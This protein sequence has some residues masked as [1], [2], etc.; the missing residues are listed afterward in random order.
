M[1]AITML[2]PAS[3]AQTADNDVAEMPEIVVFGGARDERG[4]LE[5]PNPVTIV[6][7]EEIIRRQPSTYE[8]L[9]GDE[10]GVTIEGGPRSISQEPNIRGFRDDQVLIR[11]DGARQ[12]FNIPHRG[13]FFTDPTIVKQ[14][15]I[16]R[17]GA[18]T[19]FGSGA[20]GGVI[21]LDTKDAAD[22]L[23][24][25]E[26]WGG[27]V[28]FGFNSQG[29][30]FLGAGTVV[31]QYE[32]FD[33]LAFF[34]GRPMFSD[35]ED[36]SNNDII[37]SEIDS[38]N[39]LIKLGWEPGD[40]HRVEGSYQ[41][42]RDNGDTPP[43]ANVQG[44]PTTVVDR[45]LRYQT[46]RVAWDWA[47]ADQPLI[48]LSTL[49]YFN[50][51]NVE[52]DRFFDGRFDTT[53]LTTVGIEATNISSFQIADVP[54]DV[55][56]GIEF[57]LDDRVAER[58]GAPRLQAPDAVR[59]FYAAFVQADFEVLPGLTVTPG[60]RY[61]FFQLRPDGAFPD[62]SEGQP[63]PR[64]AVNWQPTENTQ[65][66]A[67]A[68]RSFRAPALTELYNDGVHF[69]T[70]GFPLGPPGAPV[71]TGI[72]QFVPSPDL[73][74]ERATQF[75][76][77]G[78]YRMGGLISPGDDLLISG[79]VYYSIVDDFVDTVVTFIDD[80]T[81]SFNPITG[82]VEVGGTTINRNVDAVLFGFEAEIEYDSDDWFASVGVTIPRGR[83][84]G[85]PG[86]LASIPADRL[87]VT[88]GWRPLRDVELGVR[89][90]FADGVQA[91]DTSGEP[92]SGYSVFDFF[93][94]WQP[95]DG[96]LE[97]AI[98]SAGIDNLTDQEYR[99]FPNGLNSTGLA[100]KAAATFT[101]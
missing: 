39:G 13:R 51:T 70:P 10:P 30:E 8:E 68:S 5:T 23:E 81:T 56:Y 76:I 71:F 87:V 66:F 40:N 19:L 88:G 17:G 61:D 64:L 33:A 57:F 78:R 85:G 43:N 74:P 2:A 91:S 73:E 89:G 101:F 79:N 4:L 15:E 41:I 44:T 94:N 55:S 100:F 95:S 52:E 20:L 12:N 38:Q 28:K 18:S 59:R 29:T 60:F 11:I 99:I 24:P 69:A 47:P 97:G 45:D 3:Q 22:V 54:V 80:S 98:F 53:N 67:S 48:D 86:D 82:Q 77:G 83:V 26:L 46:A 72:N 34:A 84:R 27:E 16:L 37:D 96:P 50:D 42:Y 21:F 1:S 93:A 36:G 62:R 35:L 9:I 7:Q 6:G 32:D 65:V 58:D 25:D 92:T 63:S 90:T 31:L 14:I 49:V 75:E